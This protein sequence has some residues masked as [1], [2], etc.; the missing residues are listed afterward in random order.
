MNDKPPVSRNTW[1]IRVAIVLGLLWAVIMGVSFALSRA[2]PEKIDATS[3]PSTS[4]PA[5]AGT[6]SRGP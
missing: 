4:A 5:S 3:S 6:P 2:P 1:I